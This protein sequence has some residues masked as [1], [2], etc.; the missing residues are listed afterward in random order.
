[1][2]G[3]KGVVSPCDMIWNWGTQATITMQATRE[4]LIQVENYSAIRS[5]EFLFSVFFAQWELH[6]SIGGNLRELCISSTSL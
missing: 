5:P 4:V 2:A 1:M 6:R 3:S